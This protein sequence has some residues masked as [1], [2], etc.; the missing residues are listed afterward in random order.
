MKIKNIIYMFCI[1]CLYFLCGCGRKNEETELIKTSEKEYYLED[2]QSPFCEKKEFVNPEKGV[3]VFSANQNGDICTLAQDGNIKLRTH[4]GD[5]KFTCPE[6]IDLTSFYCEDTVLYAYDAV[7]REIICIDFELGNRQI[8]VDDFAVEEILRM[9]KVGS[10]MYILAVP[11]GYQSKVGANEYVDYD[12]CLFRVSLP[13][14]KC[15]KIMIENI[16]AIYGA[17][18]GKLYYYAYRDETYMLCEYNTETMEEI[19]CCDMMKT[20]GIKYLSAFVFEQNIFVYSELITPCI[21]GISMRDGSEIFQSK[22]I[23]LYSGNDIDYVHGNV[24][25]YGYLPDGTDSELQSFYI[26][27]SD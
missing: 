8:I 10:N 5:M 23:F 18:N 13:E 27:S 9:E 20:Y 21:R 11:V 3:Y 1:I 25:Y 24:I 12:E 26:T 22:E 2:I 7:K 19:V 15:E 17:E 14:G 4:L 16:L 6:C